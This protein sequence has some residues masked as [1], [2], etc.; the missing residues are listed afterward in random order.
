MKTASEKGTVG[1]V[2][3]V[4]KYVPKD[5]AE[6][7]SLGIDILSGDIYNMLCGRTLTQYS[8]RVRIPEIILK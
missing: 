1:I 8:D 2:S 3:N 6:E 7:I 4:N 5:A